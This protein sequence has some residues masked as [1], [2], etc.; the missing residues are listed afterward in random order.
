MI[1]KTASQIKSFIMY[2]QTPLINCE[3]HLIHKFLLKRFYLIENGMCDIKQSFYHIA[4]RL[5]LPPV[6]WQENDSSI[7]LMR[8]LLIILD[9][10]QLK[11]RHL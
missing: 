1:T 11:I 5:L 6:R 9:G 3:G 7:Q 10:N 4:Y 2:G 8:S